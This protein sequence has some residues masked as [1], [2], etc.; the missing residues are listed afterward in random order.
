[1]YAQAEPQS[2]EQKCLPLLYFPFQKL[3]RSS[4][5]EKLSAKAQKSTTPCTDLQK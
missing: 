5:R 4:Q 3:S 2:G 1:M